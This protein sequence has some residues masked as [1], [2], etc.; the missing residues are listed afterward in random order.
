MSTSYDVALSFANED[1]SIAREIAI[2]LKKED[3]SVFFNEDS[4]AELWGQN[5]FDYLEKVYTDSK[6]CIVILS[7]SYTEKQWTNNE[8]RNLIAHSISRPSFSILPLH[9]GDAPIP[10]GLAHIGY[11]QL[12][13]LSPQEL[14]QIVKERLASLSPPKPETRQENFH[15][16]KRE[17]GWSVKREGTS[18]AT[19]VHKTRE[20]AINNAHKLARQS[21]QSLVVVHNED[22]SI[23]SQE[24]VSKE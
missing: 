18:R 15:V 21:K 6:L 2:S 23:E 13:F 10:K 20:E 7:N 19:S 24:Q 4:S 1:R 17:T 3:I 11:V 22:G 8:L 16:I 9:I 12:D 5:L 14:T